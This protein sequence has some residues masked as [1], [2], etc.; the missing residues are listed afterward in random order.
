[1]KKIH[2]ISGLVMVLI[3]V[4]SGQYLKM[5]LPPFEGVMDGNRMMWRA[6]HI[7]LMMSAVVNVVAGMYYQ[8]FTSVLAVWAQKIG[9]ISV[10][11]SQAVLLAAFTIEPAQNDIE[12]LYTVFGC[13]LLLFGT[14]IV[15][16]GWL[17]DSFKAKNKGN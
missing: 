13:L 11:A 10:I 8:P 15:F 12:R 9:S 17:Y 4:L 16:L 3:F 1:M 14:F 7:Y 2:L 6:S 5:T